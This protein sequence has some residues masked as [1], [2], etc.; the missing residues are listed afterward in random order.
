MKSTR[1]HERLMEGP[2][3][4]NADKALP[5]NRPNFKGT[6]DWTTGETTEL[7][8]NSPLL[9]RGA[10]DKHNEK[11]DKVLA[12]RELRA[13]KARV[14]K[15]AQGTIDAAEREGLQATHSGRTHRSRSR[16][17]R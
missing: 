11:M 7:K 5:M 12:K 8:R 15:H 14:V 6:T 3:R 17:R 13:G 16:R 2:G 4:A 9:K 1:I 10:L